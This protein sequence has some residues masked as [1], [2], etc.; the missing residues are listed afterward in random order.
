[1]P[2]WKVKV[3]NYDKLILPM[4]KF[5]LILGEAEGIRVKALASSQMILKIS[6]SIKEAGVHVFCLINARE[7]ML[8]R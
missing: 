3:L 1:M 8:Y 4:V 5:K 6:E 7:K 2:S